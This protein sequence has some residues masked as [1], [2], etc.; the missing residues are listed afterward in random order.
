MR[1]LE[2]AQGTGKAQLDRPGAQS[3]RSREWLLA[4]G[5][6]AHAL[7]SVTCEAAGAFAFLC[8]AF[9]H[10]SDNICGSLNT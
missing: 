5:I 10:S 2:Q 8:A 6:P 1:E 3:S 9:L 7:P 4:E